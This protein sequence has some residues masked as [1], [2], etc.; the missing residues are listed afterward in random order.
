VRPSTGEYNPSTNS[1]VLGVD[2]EESVHRNIASSGV[3]ANRAD[4]VH[5]ETSAVVALVGETVHDVQVVVNTLVVDCKEGPGRLG[6]AQITKIDDVRHGTAGRSWSLGTLLVELVVEDHELVALI[7]PPSLVAVCSAR[8]A[9]AGEDLGCWVAFLAGGIVDGDGV[10]VVSDAD[11]AASETAVWSLVGDALG[12]VDVAI[13]RSAAGRGGVLGIGE[14]NVLE[15]TCAARVTWLSSDSNRILVVP[16]DDNIVG[17]ANGD[18]VREETNKIS[19]WVEDRWAA[20]VKV[21]EL[22]EI[23][24]CDMLAC[25]HISQPRHPYSGRCGL[26]PHSQ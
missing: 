13:L 15:T 14:I 26:W 10:L 11:V 3:P 1:I 9:E 16:V 20:R 12:V 6:V 17:T 18:S 22:V 19:Q 5:P 8:V 4:I 25:V 24:D 21:Q 7:S 2:V 23:E